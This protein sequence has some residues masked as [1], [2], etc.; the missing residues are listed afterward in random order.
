MTSA[1][2]L[3]LGLVPHSVRAETCVPSKVGSGVEPVV[4]L[5]TSIHGNLQGDI[6]G[7]TSNFI[8]GYSYY[9]QLESGFDPVTGATSGK[10]QHGQVTI[11][12]PVG[13]ASPQLLQAWHTNEVLSSVLIQTYKTDESG[14]AGETYRVTLVN[15]SVR[16]IVQRD[17]CDG[18][19]VEDVSFRYNR[20]EET[21]PE[22][23]TSFEDNWTD[24]L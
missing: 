15:A 13:R 12:Q 11:T 6:R 7:D 5:S 23:G 17:G 9:H 14:Q 21:S 16:A 10:R 22:A 4:R 19:L 24:A 2:F 8:Y 1:F 20:M 3:A 18:N